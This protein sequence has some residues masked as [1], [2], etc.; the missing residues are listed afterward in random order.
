MYCLAKELV[1]KAKEKGY[2]VSNRGKISSFFVAYLL[3]II[4]VNPL[5]KNYGGFDIPF[6]LQ[7]DIE[8]IIR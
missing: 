6:E 3:G 1:E 8:K 7:E 5:T 2:L 4:A